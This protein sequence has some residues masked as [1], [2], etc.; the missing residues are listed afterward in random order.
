M[1]PVYIQKLPCKMK[2]IRMWKFGFFFSLPSTRWAHKSKFWES[3]LLW[4]SD[5]LSYYFWS[6]RPLKEERQLL[7]PVSHLKQCWEIEPRW[8]PRNGQQAG[9]WPAGTARYPQ[10]AGRRFKCLCFAGCGMSRTS[11][12]ASLIE[13][14]IFSINNTSKFFISK[15]P[16]K[17]WHIYSTQ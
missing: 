6:G 4:F 2:K 5:K 1:D 13:N 11:A 15:L 17:S 16:G 12:L 8:P 3:G 10:P 7:K 9:P 14:I